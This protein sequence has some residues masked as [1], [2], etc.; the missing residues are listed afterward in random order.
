MQ[1]VS[2]PIVAIA[3]VLVAVFV[4]IAFISRADRPVLQAV[5]VDDRDLDGD[6][7][8]QLADVVAR[9]VGAAAAA[10]R[11]AEGSVRRARWTS[12][13]AGSSVA[14]IAFFKR[15][16]AGVLGR[17]RPRAEPQGARRCVVYAVLIGVDLVRL[18]G[19]AGRLRAAAGQA[20]PGRLRAVARRRVARPHRR[21]DPP[22]VATSRSSSRASRH[23]VAFPGL[24]ING[25]TNSPNAGIVFVTLDAVRASA[26]TL[27]CRAARSPRN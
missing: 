21:R 4:P 8:V 26:R 23:A 25:F 22:H 12:R 2:G 27:R 19:G 6:L 9:A 16:S 15:S 13:S 1:E 7:G 24:S 11:R 14:S 17:R 3:L 20:I 5:R 10:A 18:Q